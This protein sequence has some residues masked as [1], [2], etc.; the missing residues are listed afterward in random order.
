MTESFILANI[1]QIK[2][3]FYALCSIELNIQGDPALD[4]KTFSKIMR[5]SKQH[6]ELNNIFSELWNEYKKNLTKLE[7]IK[8]VN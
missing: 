3:K 8:F 1:L 6:K 5:K 7:E 4:E 2:S